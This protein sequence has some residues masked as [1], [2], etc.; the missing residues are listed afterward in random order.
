MKGQVTLS[1][2]GLTGCNVAFINGLSIV[3]K[4]QTKKSPLF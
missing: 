1:Y 3:N 4:I 2:K